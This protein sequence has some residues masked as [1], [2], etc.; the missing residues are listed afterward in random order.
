MIFFMKTCTTIGQK[1]EEDGR[2]YHSVIADTER[3]LIQ[4]ALENSRGNQI[5]AS[6]MLGVHRN[7]MR[8]KIKEL[9]IN[10]HVFKS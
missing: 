7:T 9:K 2:L 1:T 10:I 4:R 5:L 8:K 3:I 6:R